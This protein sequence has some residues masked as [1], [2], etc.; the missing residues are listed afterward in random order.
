MATPRTPR[1]LQPNEPSW[2]MRVLDQYDTVG[3]A[4]LLSPGLLVTCAHVVNTALGRDGDKEEHPGTDVTVR[5]RSFDD[6]TWEA[7]VDTQLWS[8]GPE[9]RDLAVLRLPGAGQPDTSFPVL[10]DCASLDPAQEL[11]ITGYPEGMR[12]L[13]ASLTYRGSGGPTG[14]THQVETPA[15]QAVR[16]TEGFSG[17]AVRTATGELV[18]IMQKNHYYQWGD[19]EQPSGLAFLLP[20][21]ELAGERE[22]GESVSVQRLA[23]ESLCGREAYDRLHDLLDSV[24][25]EEVPPERLLRSGEMR[26]LRRHSSGTTAWRALT[27]LWDLVPPFGE[28]PPRVVWVHHVYQ[29]TRRRRPIPPTVWSWIRQ[30]AS[31]M[32]RDWE[33]VLARDRDRRLDNRR[34]PDTSGA[35]PDNDERSP[36]TVMLFDLEPV[37]GGYQLSHSI[38]HLDERRN[39]LLE[40]TKLVGEREI[41]D[42]IADLVGEAVMQRRVSSNEEPPRLRILLPRDLLHLSVG[43]A[44]PHRDLLEYPPQLGTTYEI[45]Y[46]VRERYPPTNYLGA[47]DRWRLRSERQRSSALVEDRNVLATWKKEVHEVA[48]VLADQ[49]ITVCVVDSGHK[50]AEHVYDAVLYQGVPTVVRGPREAVLHLVE[51][52]LSREPGS[53]MRISG[54]PRYLRDRARE[55]SDSRKIAIIH[56][57]FGD[58]LTRETWGDPRD[59]D[60]FGS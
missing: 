52:L 35:L 22:D 42:E 36:D 26:Q 20:M 53:R 7:T 10:R 41:C 56:D 51:E 33:E 60:G 48:N 32:G 21:A 15:S 30:E 37:T 14:T 2:Q 5:L 13:Q 4:V 31:A 18:G 50:D 38:I 45:V 28:P 16:I 3:G 19:P 57:T 27:A 17:C 1:G 44:A 46:H 24:P 12:S 49:N 29:E 59:S 55:N 58:A 11:L 40:D 8:A 39:P 25:L 23:D 43:Q 9:S 34:G 6:R 54:L 47:S